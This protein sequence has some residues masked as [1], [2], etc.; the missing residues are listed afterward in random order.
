MPTTSDIKAYMRH[1]LW[2]S[3][4]GV[5]EEEDGVEGDQGDSLWGSSLVR[6]S[7]GHRGVERPTARERD[8]RRK[9]ENVLKAWRSCGSNQWMVAVIKAV[10]RGERAQ[11]HVL[12]GA[13]SAQIYTINSAHQ[14]DL[15]QYTAML[16]VKVLIVQT[17]KYN[18][19]QRNDGK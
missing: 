4:W 8:W 15:Q 17:V 16:T 19:P 6:S 9:K 18:P 1:T 10:K 5:V 13:A 7:P 11:S 14:T 3:D 12:P 2:V